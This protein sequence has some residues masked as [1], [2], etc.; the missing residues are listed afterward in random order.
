M[1]EV[2][3]AQARKARADAIRRARDARSAEI[4]AAETSSDAATESGDDD[5][6]GNAAPN[7]VDLIDKQMRRDQGR[8][9]RR[10]E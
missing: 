1:S 6:T 7:Y 5:H 10:G 9:Q 3:D 4:E 2:D 8:D